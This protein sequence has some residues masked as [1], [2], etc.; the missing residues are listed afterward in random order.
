MASPLLFLD[1]SNDSPERTRAVLDAVAEAIEARV[2]AAPHTAAREVS[3]PEGD[4]CPRAL[5]GE[6]RV[7]IRLIAAVTRTRVLL[8]VLDG[9]SVHVDL[10][11]D[12]VGW[13][14]ELAGAIA[15]VLEPPAAR[16]EG[17]GTGP[18]IL[19]GVGAAGAAAGLALAWSSASAGDELR[20]GLPSAETRAIHERR[21]DYA[22]AASAVW[23]GA[24]LSL[25]SAAL[26]AVI[27]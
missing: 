25:A 17:V 20:V 26:W 15:F 2:G 13:P 8:R 27:Q 1:G 3:C 11:P 23:V 5:D 16:A 4:A 14:T 12:Q 24:A 7:V 22:I 10:G 6:P 19:A 21:D 9:G 18:W